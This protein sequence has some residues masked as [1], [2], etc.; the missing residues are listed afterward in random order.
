MG[1]WDRN[2]TLYQ[3]E[4]SLEGY[5]QLEQGQRKFAQG[6]TSEGSIWLDQPVQTHVLKGSA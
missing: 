1:G 4:R 5:R 3:R 2:K 6:V